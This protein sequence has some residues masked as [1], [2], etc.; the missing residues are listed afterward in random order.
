MCSVCLRDSKAP[1]WL[2]WSEAEWVRS[3][4]SAGREGLA[5]HCREVLGLLFGEKWDPVEGSEQMNDV[6]CSAR[7]RYFTD[8]QARLTK[9][10]SSGSL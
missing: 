4:R 3:G 6:I 2:G 1:S 5:G 10:G 8:R 9:F 7:L